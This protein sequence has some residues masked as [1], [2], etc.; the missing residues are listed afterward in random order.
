MQIRE[1]QVQTFEMLQTMALFTTLPNFMS[2][3]SEVFEVQ[4][5]EVWRFSHI[6]YGKMAWRTQVVL[7]HGFHHTSLKKFYKF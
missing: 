6:L 4:A 1:L 3:R 2:F 5:S 7:Q